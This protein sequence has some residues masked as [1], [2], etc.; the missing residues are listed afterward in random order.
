VVSE[1][2]NSALILVS[3]GS[4]DVWLGGDTS[5]DIADSFYADVETAAINQGKI[6]AYLDVYGVD[7]HGSCYSTN[8]N[9]V[10]ATHPTVSVFSLGANT[11]GHPCQAVV[12]RLTTAGSNIYYTENS[13]GGIVDGDVK[14]TYSGGTTYSVAGV[15]GTTTFSTK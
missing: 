4:F 7:H 8:Q 6:G 3:V 2:D 11:Y 5:G 12:D 10:N 1:N 14:I 9:L 13:S 15:R